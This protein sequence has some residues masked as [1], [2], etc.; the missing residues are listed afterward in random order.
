MRLINFILFFVLLSNV[1]AQISLPKEKDTLLLSPHYIQY[2]NFPIKPSEVVFT[3]K[4]IFIIPLLTDDYF[5]PDVPVE[6]LIDSTIQKLPNLSELIIRPFF[7]AHEY[8]IYCKLPSQVYR[9]K[10]LQS[11]VISHGKYLFV[12]ELDPQLDQL[13]ELRKLYFYG[14]T[15]STLYQLTKLEDLTLSS[16]PDSISVLPRLEK[17]S[18]SEGNLST[19]N[20]FPKLETLT[21]GK[22]TTDSI[23]IPIKNV[24]KKIII[25]EKISWQFLQQ[26]INS[27]AQLNQLEEL[28]LSVSV[29]TT[30]NYKDSLLEKRNE[31]RHKIPSLRKLF[32]S[33]IATKKDNKQIDYYTLT[34]PPFNGYDNPTVEDYYDKNNHTKQIQADHYITK[35]YYKNDTVI[36]TKHFYRVVYDS[37]YFFNLVSNAGYLFNPNT[38]EK[39]GYDDDYYYLEKPTQ[40]VDGGASKELRTLLLNEK[41]KNLT[42]YSYEYTHQD[43]VFLQALHQSILYRTGSIDC[44]VTDS[45]HYVCY[46]NEY[47]QAAYIF[48]FPFSNSYQFINDI[49]AWGSTFVAVKKEFLDQH[50]FSPDSMWLDIDDYTHRSTW[51]IACQGEQFKTNIKNHSFQFTPLTTKEEEVYFNKLI[52]IKEGG[53]SKKVTDSIIRTLTEQ[54]P[55][56]ATSF[57]NPIFAKRDKHFSRQLFLLGTTKVWLNNE[58]NFF[59]LVHFTSRHGYTCTFKTKHSFRKLKDITIWDY[60]FLTIKKAFTQKYHI[61]PSGMSIEFDAKKRMGIWKLSAIGKEYHAYLKNGRLLF[62]Q[63]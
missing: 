36:D 56:N 6:L 37:S 54:E 53:L 44:W 35:Q 31:L 48:R 23:T 47:N 26:L 22:L 8:G 38:T 57:T 14:E 25:T 24:L 3:T 10:K 28:H 58:L 17:L 20:Y 16:L 19:L 62:R 11:L 4:L 15:P 29:P 43:S 21:I 7:P 42:A 49:T 51:R 40:I 18:L 41:C 59:S 55:Y 50:G 30:A 1:H 2:N 63:L 9:L 33:D 34:K 5:E 61:E 45:V 27:S 60:S 39:Y 32:L 46:K 13:R 52:T 12:A